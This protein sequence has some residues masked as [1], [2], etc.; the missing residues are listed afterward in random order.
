MRFVMLLSGLVLCIAL[1]SGAIGQ[2]Q[3]QAERCAQY[4]REGKCLGISA[5][6][7]N[8]IAT[9]ERFHGKTVQ[10]VGYLA[11]EF[12]HTVV[13]LNRDSTADEA[14]WVS[15][16]EGPIETEADADRWESLFKM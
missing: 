2:E 9:P 6:L 5:S 14:L 8:L 12:E 4:D 7:I 11:L 15:F 3:V 13:Y 1:S 10:V 16:G